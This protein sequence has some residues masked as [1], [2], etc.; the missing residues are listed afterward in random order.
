MYVSI[1]NN[2]IDNYGYVSII[3]ILIL[4]FVVIFVKLIIILK[5]VLCILL[6]YKFLCT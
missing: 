2:E 5:R 1:C 6:N 3:I 4:I